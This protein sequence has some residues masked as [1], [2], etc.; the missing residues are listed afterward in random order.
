MKFFLKK[1]YFL[2]VLSIVIG[3]SFAI[4]FGYYNKAV[5]KEQITTSVSINSEGGGPLETI[6][7]DVADQGV[8][9]KWL[10]PTHLITR[11]GIKNEGTEP[12]TIKV[13]AVNFTS[14]VIVESGPPGFQK[15]STE[16]VATLNPGKSIRLKVR[17]N[18]SN[19][20]LSQSQQY[21][22]ILR[23]IDQQT[24]LYLGNSLVYAINSTVQA[25]QEKTSATPAVQH[26]GHGK[27]E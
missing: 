19:A 2:T 10:Q 14:D 16:Y 4:G 1:S 11:Y 15:P 21:L 20:S 12:L 23:V 26:E 3:I 18:L 7:L 25:P 27:S 17:I 6:I 8:A 13:V 22:G 5:A 9:K 24:G